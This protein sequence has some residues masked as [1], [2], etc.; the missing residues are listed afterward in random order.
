VVRLRNRAAVSATSVHVEGVWNGERSRAFVAGTVSPGGFG[1]VRL[2]FVRSPP[3]GTHALVLLVDFATV[4]AQGAHPVNEVA[5]LLLAFDAMPPPA[6]R[7]RAGA[8]ALREAAEATVQLESADGKPHRVRLSTWLPRA[9]TCDPPAQAVEVPERGI[10]R[11]RVRVFRAAAAYDSRH[12]LLAVAETEG[13]SPV[14]TTVASLPLEIAG[15][16]AWMPRVRIPLGLAF[17]ALVGWAVH[18]QRQ[19]SA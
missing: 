5:A 18:R 17:M 15:E 2:R 4:D 11:A 3:P 12:E 9:L 14:R 6:V 1:E 8:L 16:D 10:A 19:K 13:E 7:L